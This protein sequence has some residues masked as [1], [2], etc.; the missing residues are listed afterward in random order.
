MVD[1]FYM[2]SN[3]EDKIVYSFQYERHKY[4]LYS[5]EIMDLVLGKGI[6]ALAMENLRASQ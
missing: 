3:M 4:K 6:L 2:Y 1:T 5:G